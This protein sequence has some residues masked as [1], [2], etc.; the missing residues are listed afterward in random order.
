MFEFTF[1]RMDS[2]AV[3]SLIRGLST[4]DGRWDKL[5]A[6]TWYKLPKFGQRCLPDPGM[7]DFWVRVNAATILSK[8]KS[9]AK[10]SVSALFRMML[11]DDEEMARRAAAS[12]LLA[13]G[14]TGTGVVGGMAPS[15]KG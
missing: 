3:P 11:T 4:R 7:S 8:I 5:Y 15:G 14:E 9:G 2:N 1:P 10:P 12:T 6:S 13:M